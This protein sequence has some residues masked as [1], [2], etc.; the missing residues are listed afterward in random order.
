MTKT[1]QPAARI[2][3]KDERGE[4]RNDMTRLTNQ[5]DESAEVY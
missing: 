2:L 5:A 1:M 3:Q 4:T